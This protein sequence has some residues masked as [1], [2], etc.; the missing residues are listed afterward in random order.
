MIDRAQLRGVVVPMI[1]PLH[2]DG[3][4]V[5]E[6]GVHQQVERLVSQ[7]V[8]G[9]F[10]G[11]TTGEIW[12]L[13]DQQ[14]ARLVRSAK[15]AVAGRVPLYVGVSHALHRGRRRPSPPGRAVGR[16]R[17][18]LPGP[19]LHP[20]GS[21]RHRA[22]LPGAGRM[23][24]RCPIIIYQYPGIVKTSITLAT[25]AELAKIPGVVGAQGLA[26]R[27]HRVSPHG[28]LPARRWPGLSPVP[29]HATC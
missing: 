12:A 11:G 19:L 15:E 14:F 29:G 18:C 24:H 10:V 22:P 8:H 13:D 9:V 28:P 1:T 3:V 25:Y 27:R 4:T 6:K 2:A 21:G 23:P 16:R 20:A 26:G 7:G 17:G 5:N